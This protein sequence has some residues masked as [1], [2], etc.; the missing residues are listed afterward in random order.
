MIVPVSADAPWPHTQ[1]QLVLICKEIKPNA[2]YGANEFI[3]DGKICQW[4]IIVKKT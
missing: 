4:T 3:K 1:Q 2:T